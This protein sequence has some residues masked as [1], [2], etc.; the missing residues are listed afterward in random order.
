MSA[1][2]RSS[3]IFPLTPSKFERR[4]TKKQSKKSNGNQK[5]NKSTAI[6]TAT[7]KRQQQQQQQ[8]RGNQNQPPS[9]CISFQVPANVNPAARSSSLLNGV[10]NGNGGR[11]HNG[12]HNNS[13]SQ[14]TMSQLSDAGT[15]ARRSFVTN[16]TSNANAN[17]NANA[18]GSTAI[19]STVKGNRVSRFNRASGNGNGRI[20]AQHQSQQSQ[21]QLQ[22][23]P[24]LV[25]QQLNHNQ[26]R[27]QKQQLK[28]ASAYAGN[29]FFSQTQTQTSI[30]TR[31]RNSNDNSNH[32]NGTRNASAS[33][34]GSASAIRNIHAA[35]RKRSKPYN[36]TSTTRGTT[37]NINI[38]T[39]APPG[40][41]KK[42][43][44][45]PNARSTVAAAAVAS[46]AATNRTR[47]RTGIGN[48]V[49]TRANANIANSIS[50]TSHKSHGNAQLHAQAHAQ[51][52]QDDFHDAISDEPTQEFTQ[53]LKSQ[54]LLPIPVNNNNNIS[55]NNRKRSWMETCMDVI[56]TPYRKR[57]KHKIQ[58]G[59][60]SPILSPVPAADTT[61]TITGDT[62]EHVPAPADG[63][64]NVNTNANA[65]PSPSTRTN[66]ISALTNKV[67]TSF[68]TPSRK[69]SSDT[70]ALT[71][72]GPR[73]ITNTS[74]GNTETAVV[75]HNS[76]GTELVPVPPSLESQALSH[77]HSPS[78]QT[79]TQTHTNT[80]TSL[81]TSTSASPTRQQLQLLQ[82]ISSEKQHIQ[83]ILQQITQ[84]AE[85][86]QS[87]QRELQQ[88]LQHS[89]E[90]T[91]NFH[92]L[93]PDAKLQQES[94][95]HVVDSAAL[96]SK[97]LDSKLSTGLAD[98]QTRGLQQVQTIVDKGTQV[99]LQFQ[100]HLDG[101]VKDTKRVVEDAKRNALGSIME[102]LRS[103][104]D[105]AKEEVKGNIA[106]VARMQGD[107]TK[108]TQ[109]N[110]EE[111]Q[112][113][114]E[115]RLLSVHVQQRKEAGAETETKAHIDSEMEQDGGK[116][117]AL[118]HVYTCAETTRMRTCSTVTPK[119]RIDAVAVEGIKVAETTNE[120]ADGTVTTNSGNGIPISSP[121][122][123]P[124]A[125]A[126]VDVKR[127]LKDLTNAK[128]DNAH[129]RD[130][131]VGQNKKSGKRLAKSAKAESTEGGVAPSDSQPVVAAARLHVRSRRKVKK[132][133]E[134][135]RKGPAAPIDAFEL[136]SIAD[137]EKIAL[138][139]S[140][141]SSSKS[142]TRSDTEDI[143]TNPVSSIVNEA[144]QQEHD[145]AVQNHALATHSQENF[146]GRYNLRSKRGSAPPACTT[147]HSTDSDQN[148]SSAAKFPAR[149]EIQKESL[150][151]A[152]GH[153]TQLRPKRPVKK[154]QRR[155]GN[156]SLLASSQNPSKTHFKHSNIENMQVQVQKQS[157]AQAQAQAQAQ[158]QAPNAPDDCTPVM[159]I[160]KEL[161]SAPPTAA[162]KLRRR[163]K[164]T[165]QRSR[166]SSSSHQIRVNT[167]RSMLGSLRLS[168]LNISE[169]D[170]RM[171]S[172]PAAEFL[173]GVNELTSAPALPL[174]DGRRR[175]AQH[176]LGMRTTDVFEF[177]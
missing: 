167:K 56:T 82:Q 145:V 168:N 51:Y 78:K 119:T 157:Q 98:I 85:K 66:P 21:S 129:V 175:R 112:R 127:A 88:L 81:A 5:I 80:K 36:S 173:D 10:T 76:T 118:Q 104:V 24:L 32:A 72:T 13:L 52:S 164:Q 45:N 106:L 107:M 71:V 70:T 25:K 92:K 44:H 42:A 144:I 55:N 108:E 28:P 133:I 124:K 67:L 166:S 169:F 83:T 74:I 65:V 141:L 2:A 6:V 61:T 30:D 77:S 43:N 31:T 117:S 18:T 62:N 101:S 102:T 4:N 116:T 39:K 171:Q 134:S 87:V 41:S 139:I 162:P 115:V 47:T 68:Q 38:N 94:L 11:V 49:Q 126:S 99:Q 138:N 113:Q 105:G 48:R 75:A 156:P 7:K 125:K 158:V 137:R 89:Q 50:Q 153:T 40:S 57:N 140:P 15:I 135:H 34:S 16:S 130:K 26:T 143:V 64:T 96:H 22:S 174:L 170:T 14:L 128:E 136:P 114:A 103:M 9:S 176:S 37:A 160:R 69:R 54:P 86:Q 19:N 109:V 20:R 3:S 97:E 60:S 73:T 131:R 58:S 122:S 146:N 17:I 46:A 159:L 27:K 110:M 142:I 163:R 151:P 79:H 121:A 33:A 147:Q 155:G 132:N 100:E 53:A 150:V 154:G 120:T 149:N 90:C 161:G 63:D 93:L 172:P 23:Q 148:K 12:H 1:F 35:S 59:N 84:Q 95:Q 177:A 29:I 8:Q 91:S 123:L 111:M 152:K 165:Y